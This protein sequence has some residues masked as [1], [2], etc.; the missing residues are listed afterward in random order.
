MLSSAMRRLVTTDEIDEHMRDNTTIPWL[1][2]ERTYQAG[3]AMSVELGEI[4]GD[5][6]MIIA[7]P[8]RIGRVDVA[9]K[10]VTS[11]NPVSGHLP[12]VL[13]DWWS[14]LEDTEQFYPLSP[15]TL[16]YVAPI[17]RHDGAIPW[18]GARRSFDF[19]RWETSRARAV[20]T[21]AA[22]RYLYGPEPHIGRDLAKRNVEAY[23]RT[24]RDVAIEF[25]GYD[26]SKP[27][28]M[29]PQVIKLIPPGFPNI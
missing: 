8:W 19:S 9:L 16:L 14:D 17:G 12:L 1:R 24:S 10:L 22:T 23:D 27:Q 26:P 21:N 15:D 13:P 18:K 6:R 25:S 2:H 28:E 7:K 4:T 5:A 3:E 20:I 11:D 29:P